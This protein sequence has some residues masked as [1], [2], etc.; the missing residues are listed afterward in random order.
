MKTATI[1]PHQTKTIMNRIIGVGLVAIILSE[2]GTGHGAEAKQPN[3]LFVLADQ[4]RPQSFGFNGNPDVKTPTFDRLAEESIRLPNAVAGYPVCCPT[5]AS[6]L[7]GRLPLTHGVFLNDVSLPDEEI[8]TAEVLLEH[9]YQTGYIGKWHLD[10]RGRSNYTPPER[11]QGFQYWKALECSHNYNRSA[12]YENTPEKQFWEGY[13]AIA[14]TS[15]AI[16]FIR[17]AAASNEPFFL[18]LAWGPPHAPYGT[19]PERYKSLYDPSALT[20]RPNVPDELHDR[21]RRDLAGYYA[22]CT[23][24]DD[25]M[26]RLLEAL[27]SSGIAESTIVIFTSEH[28]DL[29]GSHGA[30]KKQQP[31]EESVRVP[32]LIRWP[33]GWGEEGGL[34]SAPINSWD[35][36]PTLLGLLDL[37]IPEQVQGIDLSEHLRGGPDPTDGAAFIHCPAPFGQWNRTRG[38]KEY[39]GIRTNRYTYTRDLEGPWLLFDNLE[40]PYQQV[41]LIGNPKYQ[42]VQGELERTLQKK[43]DRFNDAFRPA[44]DYIKEFGYQVNANGTVPY[45]P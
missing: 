1:V 6:L 21:V 42:D 44:S 15:D 40:D 14:Q 13:D 25:C 10:G 9:G 32:M 36:M 30:Y 35:V 26:A 34:R 8:T 20:L 33:D 37:P 41:N 45:T 31:F 19:A 24:L 23:A 29:L 2:T 16:G 11:R 22:H 38:G 3:V 17:D 4:W 7:T 39:R 5:R 12:Y 43:L 27:E 18:Q 28:G